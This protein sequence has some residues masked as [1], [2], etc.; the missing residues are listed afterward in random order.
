[1]PISPG[2]TFEILRYI[3][4]FINFILLL[5]L[6]VCGTPKYNELNALLQKCLIPYRRLNNVPL[7]SILREQLEKASNEYGKKGIIDDSNTPLIA[8]RMNSV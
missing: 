5:S 3:T 2:L 8:Y 7:M 6:A 4:T 1:M